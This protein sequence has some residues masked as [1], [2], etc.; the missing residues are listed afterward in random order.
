MAPSAAPAPAARD[1]LDDLFDYDVELDEIFG[2]KLQTATTTK[3][4]GTN[5]NANAAR[6]NCRTNGA[7]SGLGLDEEVVVDKKV[8]APRVKLDEERYVWDTF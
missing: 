7:G 4:S 5:E 2:D 3:A 8:R 6:N 1:D